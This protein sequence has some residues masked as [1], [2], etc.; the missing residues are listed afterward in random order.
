MARIRKPLDPKTLNLE[1]L[2][3]DYSMPCTRHEVTLQS[4]DA[5]SLLPHFLWVSTALYKLGLT[6][7]RV[8]AE[9]KVIEA[10]RTI[11][12]ESL[13]PLEENLQ[14]EFAR[15]DRLFK[16]ARIDPEVTF[17]RPLTKII[18]I[19][20]PNARRFLNLLTGLDNML[21]QLAE[22]WFAGKI[23][24]GQYYQG[25]TFC[26]KEL[27][28]AQYMITKFVNT[29]M[30]LAG[31]PQAEVQDDQQ[32]GAESSTPADTPE[33]ASKGNGSGTPEPQKTSSRGSGRGGKKVMETATPATEEPQQDQGEGNGPEVPVAG[34][35]GE[36]F[37]PFAMQ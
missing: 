25:K 37:S 14:A 27:K 9:E 1:A 20:Y 16:A 13:K 10:Q 26:R 21:Y 3:L 5:Q 19:C 23:D 18:D 32:A 15:V 17:S 12:E 34:P 24:D 11:Y 30:R 8:A 4:N 35:E 6:M 36:G 31:K 2:R 33:P 7:R 28:N 29:S 22:L